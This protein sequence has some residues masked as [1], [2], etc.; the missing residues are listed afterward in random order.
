MVQAAPNGSPGAPSVTRAP[1]GE[2]RV[3]LPAPV[4]Q[5]AASAAAACQLPLERWVEQVVE[6][7]LVDEACRH[8]V[9]EA[10]GAAEPEPEP[11]EDVEDDA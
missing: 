5:R 6:A 11:L 10:G 9:R 2:V 4:L 3:R 1:A 7:R 8:G